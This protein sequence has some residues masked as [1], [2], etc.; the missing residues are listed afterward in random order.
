MAFAQQDPGIQTASRGTGASLIPTS[1]TTGFLTFFND[2]LSRFQEVE[3]VSAGANVGLG[4]RFNSNSCVSCHAQPTI[5]GSGAAAGSPQFTFTTKSDGIVSGAIAAGNTMPSFITSTGPTREARFPFMMNA[6]GTVDTSV[7]SGNVEDIFTVAGR[8]DRGTCTSLA[9]PNF[10]AAEAAGNVIFRIPTPVFGLGLVENLDDST[11]LANQT[12][13]LANS[14]GIGGTFNRSGND[15]TITKFGWKAQNKS[16][17]IFAGEAYNVEMGI[18]NLL[19][20]NEKCCS[21]TKSR[22]LKRRWLAQGCRKH[23]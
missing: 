18:T 21:P 3:T 14:F 5:G 9:Q 17:H 4:P 7:P 16:L 1:D 12:K 13:N 15:N 10:A 20:T 2:G 6:N 19:F 8:S 23:A 22:C 11:L